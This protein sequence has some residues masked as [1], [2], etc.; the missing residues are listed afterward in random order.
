MSLCLK[1]KDHFVLAIATTFKYLVQLLKNLEFILVPSLVF[2]KNYFYICFRIHQNRSL[3]D[4][5]C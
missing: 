5:R 3:D 2:S 4:A 1:F